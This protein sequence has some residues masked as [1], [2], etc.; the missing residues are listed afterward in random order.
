M[1]LTDEQVEYIRG[2][3]KTRGITDA[4]LA[5][6][7]VDHICCAIEDLQ[8]A[9]FYAAYQQVIVS[10]K[11]NGLFKIQQEI[12]LITLTKKESVMKKSMYVMGYIALFLC[13]TGLLFK[14]QSWPGAAVMLVLGIVLLNV[15][16]LPMY[17]VS[18]Y[19]KA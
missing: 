4:N 6:S 2:D 8:N 18:R 1:I 15:V 9:D 17:L 10:F 16:V 12:N 7:L 11:T 14:V 19:R 3:I 13:T 5:E